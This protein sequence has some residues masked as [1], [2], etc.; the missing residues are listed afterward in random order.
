MRL[1]YSTAVLGL[2][3]CLGCLPDEDALM[4]E[5]MPAASKPAAEPAQDQGAPSEPSPGAEQPS[6]PGPD[7]PQAPTPAA[8]PT[9]PQK[10]PAASDRASAPKPAAPAP[11]ATAPPSQPA[12]APKP[13]G[14]R[15]K[16]DVGV[17][18]K[19]RSLDEFQGIQGAIAEPARAFFRVTERV[20]FQ[21][22][23][24]QA[25]NLYKASHGSAP[26]SH[27]EFMTQ[28]IQANNIQL[29]E[30]PPGHRYVY[31]PEKAELMVER[32]R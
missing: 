25:L 8:G 23:I 11:K 12:P 1:L 6:A 15:V 17:G 7:Q 18:K 4:R 26:K 13:K 24:P 19:G 10:A 21:V 3:F 27:E 5:Q 14:D 29:P 2:A 30:L 9:A 16:A 22:Q 31:D 28:I 32:P 20:I